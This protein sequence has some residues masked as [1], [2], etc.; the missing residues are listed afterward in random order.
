MRLGWKPSRKKTKTKNN[1]RDANE[2]RKQIK[3]YTCRDVCKGMES[4]LNFLFF[5]L[6]EKERTKKE[7]EISSCQPAA[8]RKNYLK[9]LDIIL[10]FSCLNVSSELINKKKVTW[11]RKKKKSWES[12]QWAANDISWMLDSWNAISSSSFVVYIKNFYLGSHF[13][14]KSK[15]KSVNWKI[16]WKEKMTSGNS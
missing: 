11:T 4:A 13:R 7:Q 15:H 8:N 9:S 1:V 3:N 14:Q 16:W 2:T 10:P 5:S 12:W 6:F